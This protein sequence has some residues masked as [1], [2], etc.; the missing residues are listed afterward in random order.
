MLTIYEERGII[1]GKRGA[2]L[3]QLRFKFGD[4]P[5]ATVAGLQ[6]IGTEAELDAL[7]ERVLGA[8][9]LHDMGLGQE[10]SVSGK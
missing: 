8:K 9:T 5:E 3:R 4:L 2:L 10:D 6:G 1:K 7:L